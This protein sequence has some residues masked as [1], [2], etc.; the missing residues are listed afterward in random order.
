MSSSLFYAHYSL[1]KYRHFKLLFRLEI[2]TQPGLLVCDDYSF[3]LK[4][5]VLNQT[6]FP[7]EKLVL[8]A[9][10]FRCKVFADQL[11]GTSW[12]RWAAQNGCAVIK[13]PE[14]VPE[15]A[16]V[17]NANILENIL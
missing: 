8:T 17:V 2:F 11:A 12:A 4:E 6:Q 3:K 1:A 15:L 16:L 13:I 14:L 7:F 9:T 5:T 10:T